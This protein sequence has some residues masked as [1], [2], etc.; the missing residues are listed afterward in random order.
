M[1]VL[2]IKSLNK[3]MS[4]FCLYTTFSIWIKTQESTKGIYCSQAISKG[5]ELMNFLGLLE[6]VL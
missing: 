5:D 2:C 4:D 3:K 1:H 6:F